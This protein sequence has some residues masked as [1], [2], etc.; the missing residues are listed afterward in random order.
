MI[1]QVALGRDIAYKEGVAS[2]VHLVFIA[3]DIDCEG[4]DYAISDRHPVSSQARWAFRLDG[5]HGLID[6][7]LINGPLLDK[8]DP[9]HSY[10]MAEFLV[11]DQL[12]WRLVREIGVMT[13]AIRSSV[14]EALEGAPHKPLVT[15]RPEW[16]P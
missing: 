3:E 1:R 15:I 8:D 16:Y 11:R 13:E 9:G 2:I 12:P 7:S 14:V 4:L 6:W 10:Q 5:M